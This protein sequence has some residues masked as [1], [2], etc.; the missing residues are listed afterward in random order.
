M[1]IFESLE[2]LNVSEECFN[3]ILDMVEELLNEKKFDDEDVEYG[4]KVVRKNALAN[5]NSTGGRYTQ[6]DIRKA[7]KEYAEMLKAPKVFEAFQEIWEM[8]KAKAEY[9]SK[10][11]FDTEADKKHIDKV[12]NAGFTLK[13]TGNGTKRVI[14]WER[15][16][17]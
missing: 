10:G 7:R 15:M 3:E 12:Y 2:Q 9:D 8:R 13:D 4:F 14:E 11:Y 5:P 1:D 6:K 17:R 16:K